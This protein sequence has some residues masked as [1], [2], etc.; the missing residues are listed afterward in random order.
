MIGLFILK[1]ISSY[2]KRCVTNQKKN[3]FFDL[4]NSATT[5]IGTTTLYPELFW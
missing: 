2:T 5:S 4:T 1:L 3:Y